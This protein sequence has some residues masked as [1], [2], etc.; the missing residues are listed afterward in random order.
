[1]VVLHVPGGGSP[2]WAQSEPANVKPIKLYGNFKPREG[3]LVNFV[4]ELVPFSKDKPPLDTGD[5]GYEPVVSIGGS[6]LS[7][8]WEREIEWE[9]DFGD[10]TDLVHTGTQ[11]SA[12]HRYTD[13]SGE[14]WYPLTLTARTKDGTWKYSIER[15]IEVKNK[16]PYV[17]V[18]AVEIDA[19][20]GLSHRATDLVACVQH[21][22]AAPQAPAP[23]AG[24]AVIEL[25]SVGQRPCIVERDPPAIGER[26]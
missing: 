8:S 15:K 10:G 6:P 3:A 16:R 2:V 17:R 22:S 14:Y 21:G 9:W 19:A 5:S 24:R 26:D 23:G 13:D 20:E 25:A 7:S 4:A 11:P 1:M 12:S 18:K